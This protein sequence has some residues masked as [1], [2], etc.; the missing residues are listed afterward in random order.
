[1]GAAYLFHLVKGA[2]SLLLFLDA[3]SPGLKAQPDDI[4]RT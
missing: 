3:N 1:M 4:V 2:L